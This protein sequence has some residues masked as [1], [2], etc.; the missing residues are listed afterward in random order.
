MLSLERLCSY[1][2]QLY[3]NVT[4]KEVVPEDERKDFEEANFKLSLFNHLTNTREGKF[5]CKKLQISE[6]EK[7]ISSIKI[8]E[9]RDLKWV[10][11]VLKED[12][13]IQQMDG[14]YDDWLKDHKY[15]W[16]A[17]SQGV[18]Y[19]LQDNAILVVFGTTKQRED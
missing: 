7:W 17:N 3:C 4:E 10:Q 11:K 19:F 6:D 8:P 15:W 12:F 13:K 18:G 16:Y 1:K 14:T 5:S 2:L 9:G